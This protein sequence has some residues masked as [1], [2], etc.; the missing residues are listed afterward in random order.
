LWASPIFNGQP[1]T[2]VIHCYGK[3][4]TLEE[5]SVQFAEL[6]QRFNTALSG[7]KHWD[8][9]SLSEQTYQEY[10]TSPDMM[11]LQ[12]YYP[13]PV[14]VH[15]NYKF[16]SKVDTLIVPLVGRHASSAAI[17]GRLGRYPTAGSFHIESMTLLTDYIASDNLC[18]NP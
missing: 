3:D 6:N 17:F 1:S 10:Q 2:I 4:I 18:H 11:V 8:D 7:R 9:T 15:S 14:R 13:E 12:L 16:F 5:G